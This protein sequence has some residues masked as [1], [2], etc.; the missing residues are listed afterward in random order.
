MQTTAL[1]LHNISVS[2]ADSSG[3]NLSYIFLIACLVLIMVGISSMWFY[4]NTAEDEAMTVIGGRLLYNSIMLAM[5]SCLAL[6][7]RHTITFFM[8]Y[9]LLT[10]LILIHFA[11]IA[12]SIEPMESVRFAIRMML[13]VPFFGIVAMILPAQTFIRIIIGFF[14]A[15]GVANFL[16]TLAI[17]QYAIM[18]GIHE[19]SWRGLFSHKN[20]FGYFCAYGV[21]LCYNLLPRSFLFFGAM[22]FLYA[23]QLVLSHS[24]GALACAAAG[25]VLSS[26]LIYSPRIHWHTKATLL[27]VISVTIIAIIPFYGAL[28]EWVLGLLGKDPSLTNRTDI[29]D[30][31]LSEFAKSPLFGLGANAYLF[32]DA[33]ITRVKSGMMTDEMVSPHNGYISILI[34]TGV[35]GLLVYL[36]IAGRIVVSGI[37]GALRS[38]PEWQ[39]LLT[40]FTVLHLVRGVGETGGSIKLTIYF[41]LIVVAYVYMT[42]KQLPQSKSS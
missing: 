3:A 7:Y 39:K 14:L 18:S 20:Q 16:Y 19:G 1:N 17:P 31:Y 35:A 11:S 23:I 37:L 6:F 22:A 41:A 10:A 42:T 21:V 29:W 28:S 9:K 33:F 13:L 26:A 8:Q 4:P 2:S 12:V 25:I 27:F 40:I 36:C 5:A 32:N 15:A 34:Q 24:G 38:A 30:I